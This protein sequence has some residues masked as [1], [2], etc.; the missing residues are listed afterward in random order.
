MNLKPK[1]LPN[2]D[3]PIPLMLNSAGFV[4]PCCHCDTTKEDEQYF[5]MMGFIDE[6][7]HISNF[8]KIEDILSQDHWVDFLDII[9]T[10]PSMAA[11]A[12]KRKCND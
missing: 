3:R 6:S 5:Q 12:C 1:C 2:S 7:Q 11:P 9:Q 10:E 8:N 4:L